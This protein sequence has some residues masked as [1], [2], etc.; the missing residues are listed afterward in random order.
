MTSLQHKLRCDS[1]QGNLSIHK[2][3][4][5]V[6]RKYSESVSFSQTDGQYQCKDRVFKETNQPGF[7]YGIECTIYKIANVVVSPQC[8]SG[9]SNNS[10]N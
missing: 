7:V 8:D 3:Y 6:F 4:I 5:Y 9:N 10:T 2:S 1:C